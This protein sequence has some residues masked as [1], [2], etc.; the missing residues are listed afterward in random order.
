MSATFGFPSAHDYMGGGGGAVGA[1]G[2]PEASYSRKEKSLGLLCDNF[3]RLYAGHDAEEICLDAAAQRLAVGRRRIYDIVNVL[4][5]IEVISRKEK[6]KFIWQGL[7]RL[8]PALDDLERL[9]EQA[10][11]EARRSEAGRA[12]SSGQDECAPPPRPAPRSCAR[13]RLTRAPAA[14]PATP[15]RRADAALGLRALP[16]GAADMHVPRKDKSLGILSR[17]FMRK[18]LFAASVGG[19]P[20]VSLEQAARALDR[21]PDEAEQ[22]GEAPAAAE[23]LL[24][25]EESASAKTRL[26]RL[27]D[28]ANVL[29]ALHLVEK[30]TLQCRKPAFRWAGITQMTRQVLSSMRT[31]APTLHADAEGGPHAG[32]KRG[33]SEGLAAP[34][35]SRQRLLAEEG[36]AASA[37]SLHALGGLGSLASL[38]GLA[39]S[40]ACGL[41]VVGS[42]QGMC[43]IN[44]FL[45]NAYLHAMLSGQMQLVGQLPAQL[46]P[47]EMAGAAQGAQPAVG[48]AFGAGL[49]GPFSLLAQLSGLDPTVGAAALANALALGSAGG[50]G[51]PLFGGLGGGCVPEDWPLPLPGTGAP[52]VAPPFVDITAL[53]APPAAAA[54]AAAPPAEAAAYGHA[55]E[56]DQR[57]DAADGAAA[58]DA[59]V[60]RRPSGLLAAPVR[61]FVPLFARTCR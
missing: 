9:P 38:S 44:P 33:P 45:Y 5:S 34:L 43:G 39:A 19:S 57:A 21:L 1:D 53:A 7:A 28:I 16:N 49:G 50:A 26:R 31:P 11:A 58:V 4:E 18:L 13:I 20:I 27:Y 60:S 23:G 12:E 61:A 36:A 15:P 2:Y 41:G 8:Q 30:V 35:G 47:V 59:E 42:E 56:L 32:S 24:S 48:G 6:N 17:R 25:A 51:G 10:H 52:P 46:P 14:P 40:R 29:C 37:A 54:P 55:D 3:L 22:G